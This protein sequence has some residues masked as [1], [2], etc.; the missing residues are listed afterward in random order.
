[1]GSSKRLALLD[2]ESREILAREY[3]RLRHSTV[4]LLGYSVMWGIPGRFGET[5]GET[6]VLEP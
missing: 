2:A 3:L 4:G 1:M 5:F 6:E